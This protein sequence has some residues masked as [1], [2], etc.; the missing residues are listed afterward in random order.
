[1]LTKSSLVL[2]TALSLFFTLATT[3]KCT[4]QSCAIAALS[5]STEESYEQIVGTS[6]KS[7]SGSNSKGRECITRYYKELGIKAPG[8][9]LT[10]PPS[11]YTSDDAVAAGRVKKRDLKESFAKGLEESGERDVID[12]TRLLEKEKATERETRKEKRAEC[13]PHGIFFARGTTE[14]GV[15]GS[16]VGPAI[17]RALGSK[18]KI[19][20]VAYTADIAGDDCIGF[21]G[22]IKCRDQLEK[23]SDACP[24]T[25]W[26]LSG[27]S[28]GAMVA[29][30][31]TAFSRPEIKGK[32]RGV[33]VFGDPFNGASIKGFPSDGIKTFCNPSDGVCKGEFKISL[34][35]LSY[36]TGGSISEAAK[37][38]NSRAAG[39]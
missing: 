17:S 5:G 16:T 35:H 8:G 12:P 26:F 11:R 29:R 2:L 36:A 37:W 19:E 31:C 23:L 24:E 6:G 10:K 22:G 25:K 39:Q 33:V 32:I 3:Q 28:Q 30:I 21:P 14:R 18:W 4:G 1:M 34:G 9:N 38:M 13:K 20:G 15:M 27:Y 7:P